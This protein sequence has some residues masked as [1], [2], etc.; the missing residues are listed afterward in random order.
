MRNVKIK[1]EISVKFKFKT[2]KFELLKNIK[3]NLH[4]NSFFVMK[5]NFQTSDPTIN[6]L[7]TNFTEKI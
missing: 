2:K 6:H 1:L 7:N 5:N 4:Y 3:T